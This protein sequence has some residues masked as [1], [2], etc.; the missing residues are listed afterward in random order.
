MSRLGWMV[1]GLSALLPLSAALFL[2]NEHPQ[3]QAQPATPQSAP[4]RAPSPKELALS[5]LS[6]DDAT[7]KVAIS[8]LVS[9]GEA[10]IPE[11]KALTKDLDPKVAARAREA[12]GQ[13]TGQWGGGEGIL[14]KRSVNAAKDQGKPILVLH[15]FGK[16]DE[17]FC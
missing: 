7:A 12:L 2:V 13:I 15:L 16:F 17:E 9:M 5:G 3:A 8:T 14:W 1:A 11:L 6:L 4:S 10:V